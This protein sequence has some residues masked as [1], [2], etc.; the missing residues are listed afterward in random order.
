MMRESLNNSLRFPLNIRFSSFASALENF[1]SFTTR[2]NQ[3]YYFPDKILEL[4]DINFIYNLI[5]LQYDFQI[6]ELPNWNIKRDLIKIYSKLVIPKILQQVPNFSVE[7]ISNFQP[8]QRLLITSN[9]KQMPEVLSKLSKD[10]T[11]EDYLI[12]STISAIKDNLSVKNK[13]SLTYEVLAGLYEVMSIL[14]KNN[15]LSKDHLEDYCRL[16]DNVI[17][18]MVLMNYN[19]VIQDDNE[20]LEDE[21]LI[22]QVKMLGYIAKS[23]ILNNSGRFYSSHDHCRTINVRKG[24]VKHH[25]IATLGYNAID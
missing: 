25:Y 22:S 10:N 14:A 23:I 2:L 12:S 13:N 18:D 21:L 7:N 5:R 6:N 9:V 11:H 24:I 1:A 8:L 16:N 4:F 19:L 3:F 15:L 20:K 17:L